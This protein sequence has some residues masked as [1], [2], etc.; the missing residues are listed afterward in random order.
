MSL[1]GV[2]EEFLLAG[3]YEKLG[4]FYEEAIAQSPDRISDYWYLS[5]AYLL[6]EKEEEA[7]GIWLSVFSEVEEE[8]LED[9]TREL[10]EILERE[11]SRQAEKEN[12]H[13]AWVIRY[14]I[15]EIAPRYIENILLVIQLRIKLQTFEPNILAE[16]EVIELLQQQEDVD[17][18]LLLETLREVIIYPDQASLRFAEVGLGYVRD[19]GIAVEQIAAV[20]SKLMML[21]KKGAEYGIDL[22]NLCRQLQPDNLKVIKELFWFNFYH[23]KYPQALEVAEEFINKA[24]TFA[25]KIFGNFQLIS[26]YLKQ[27]D[28]LQVQKLASSHKKLI[29]EM[30]RIQPEVKEGYLKESFILVAQPLLYL[31]DNPQ[32]N[33]PLQNK[34]SRLFQEGLYPTTRS[35]RQVTSKAKLRIGYIAHTLKRH[36]VGWLSRWLLRYHNKEAFEIALYLVNQA[37]DSLTEEWFKASADRFY[38]FPAN[39]GAIIRQIEEDEIDILVDLDSL[40]LNLTCKVLAAKPAPIQVT[41]LGLDASGLPAID[42]FIADPYVLPENA[43]SY[44]QEKIWRLPH[45]YVAIDGFEVAVPNLR[46]EDLGI[47][48]EAMVY[49]VVQGGFKR[50]PDNI[51]WQMEIIKGVENSFL[52]IKGHANEEMTRGLYSEMAMAVGVSPERL[53]FLPLDKTE[54]IHRANLAIA[55]VVLDTYPYNGATTTLEVLWMGIPIVTRVGEQ[56]AARNSYTFMLNAGLTEG[57]AYTDEEYVEWGVKFGIDEGLRE[58]VVRKLR[59]SRETSPLWNA[60]EFTLE[61]EKAY[62]Q[63]WHKYIKCES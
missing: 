46:R 42:Y 44:Y 61:M 38:N 55:D 16:L 18:G 50:H 1:N 62:E 17:E 21:P 39:T 20:A 37:E 6:Q 58:E 26:L 10:V 14:H 32:E 3:D 54:E 60:K 57:I 27:A 11:A 7:Q 63:M 5:L 2:A 45:T 51:R 49:L 56:F 33:R 22:L 15:L 52:L 8:Q 9:Y 53:R 19:L 40:T 36:S 25:G 30:A 28:W 24:S 48:V 59:R 12:Y 34:I 35:P 41:W 13:L 47:P 23:K 29:E 43:Q 31:E 4:E